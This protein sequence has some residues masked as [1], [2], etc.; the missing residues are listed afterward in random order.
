MMQAAGAIEG[1]SIGLDG[2]RRCVII[3]NHIQRTITWKEGKGAGR[4]KRK[5]EREEK[6]ERE[7]KEKKKTHTHKKDNYE[8]YCSLD[9][10]AEC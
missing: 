10:Y 7:R 9:R 4:R 3:F 2:M 8:T 1:F 6:R 5:K